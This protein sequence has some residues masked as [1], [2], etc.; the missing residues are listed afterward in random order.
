MS[1]KT[2]LRTKQNLIAALESAGVPG[3]PI[4]TVKEA[5]AAPQVLARGLK[6]EPEGLLGLRTP[7][8]FSRSP[9]VL[10]K[11][12]PIL[13]GCIWEFAAREGEER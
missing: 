6:I 7:I 1:E 12:G 11:A 13:S 8:R 2:R 5:I 10:D 4:N 9:L 3:G